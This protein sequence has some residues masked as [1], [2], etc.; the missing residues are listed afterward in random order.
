MKKVAIILSGCGS[1][2]GSEIREALFAMLALSQQN[3][4]YQCFAPNI[5]QTYVYNHYTNEI[6]EGEK[7]NVLIE[8]ARL[9]RGKVQDLTLLN[10]SD[11][12]GLLFAGGYGAAIN[13]SDFAIVK[14]IDFAVNK[15]IEAVMK[16]FHSTLKP[17][18]FLCISPILGAKVLKN[19]TITLGNSS[20]DPSNAAAKLGANVVNTTTNTPI[21]D[22]KNKIISTPCYMLEV[23]TS[24]L[25]EGI[26]EA[27]K[28]M[29]ELLNNA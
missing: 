4:K 6:S 24:E 27:I 3:I 14:S 28:K 29:Q 22:E 23:S 13:L 5:E 12:D 9:A 7:R 8:S 16:S 26:F 2:D 1:L 21:V 25:Y 15:N 17:I 19:I 18:C 10:A 11:F 20:N